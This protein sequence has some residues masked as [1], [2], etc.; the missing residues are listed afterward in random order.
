MVELEICTD[1]ATAIKTDLAP[2]KTP[3]WVGGQSTI[4]A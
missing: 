1:G 2:P 3:L 4:K